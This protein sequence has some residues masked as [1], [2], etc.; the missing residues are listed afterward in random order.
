MANLSED[1]CINCFN[2]ELII[3]ELKIPS[4][5]GFIAA[6]VWK[7]N[8]NNPSLKVLAI[9]GWQVRYLVFILISKN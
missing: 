6:K 2:N 4:S 3:D 1:N 8:L 9:H 5:Y 7:N